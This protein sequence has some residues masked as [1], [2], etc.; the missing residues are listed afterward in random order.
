MPDNLDHIVESSQAECLPTV[1]EFTERPLWHPEGYLLFVNN[2][3]T[4]KF[5]LW[6]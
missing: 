5:P 3:L 1:F 6:G 2:H 4:G